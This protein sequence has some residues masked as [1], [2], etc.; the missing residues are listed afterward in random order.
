MKY[1]LIAGGFN[2]EFARYICEINPDVQTF[3]IQDANPDLNN[4]KINSFLNIFTVQLIR[5][6]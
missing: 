1:F 4:V 5:Y 2:S 6:H 3:V